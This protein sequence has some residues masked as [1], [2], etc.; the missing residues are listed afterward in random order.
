M[1]NS[2]SQR[3]MQRI[4]IIGAL[5]AIAEAAARIWAKRG[6]HL[7][8]AAR[9]PARLA[10][11]ANDLKACGATVE[12]FAA[13]LAAVDAGQLFERMTEGGPVDAVLISYG[14]LGDQA[15]AEKEPDHAREILAVNFTSTASWCLA[16]AN[17]L[18]A[19]KRGTLVVVGSVAGD[20]GRASNYVYG[21][22]KG[23]I[24]V[25]VQGLAHRLSRSGARAVLVK[26]GFVDTPMTAHI[27][28]KGALWAKPDRIG[29]AIVDSADA[30]GWGGPIVY[31]PWFWRWIMLLIRATPSAVLHRTSL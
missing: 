5:S 15:R 10:A 26:P 14:L 3:R 17:V 29:R 9:D 27:A 25:L 31:A 4:V 30:K 21:A 20:R 13:D 23:G 7:I 8:L 1:T 11:V 19:Q 28:G 18:E 16:A 12:T 24:G 2:E 6:A 22:A